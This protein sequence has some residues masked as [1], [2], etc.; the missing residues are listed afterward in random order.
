MKLI[1]KTEDIDMAPEL[2]LRRAGYSYMSDRRGGNDSFVR[3]L[4]RGLYP[5]FHIY[6]KDKSNDIILNI[7]LDHKKPSYPGA[8]AHSGEYDGD[9]VEAEVERLRGLVTR[10][11]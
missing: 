2:W 9:L 4:G 6:I 5:R 11:A 8:P 3:R 10:N 1:I 7:H